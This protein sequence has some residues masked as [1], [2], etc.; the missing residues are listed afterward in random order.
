[1]ALRK[2]L[3][4]GILA[5]GLGLSGCRSA[6]PPRFRTWFEEPAPLVPQESSGNAFDGYVLAAMRASVDDA[7]G[8][9]RVNFPGPERTASL[10]RMRPALQIFSSAVRKPCDFEFRAMMPFKESPY[11]AGFR[12]IGRALVWQ[13]ED[14]IAANATGEIETRVAQ[15]AKFAM[16]LMRGGAPEA[17]LGFQILDDMRRALAPNLDQLSP[18]LLVSIADIFERA[19]LNT[20]W[21]EPAL[22]NERTTMLAGVQF[23]QDAYRSGDYTQLQ[24]Q[25]GGEVREAVE[26]FKQLRNR[27]AR[28]QEMYFEGFA[29]E[30]DRELNWVREQMA[31]PMRERTEIDFEGERR[32]WRRFS[33]HFF[34]NLRPLLDRQVRTEARTKLMILECR[35][36]AQIKS[37]GSAP[38]DLSAFPK[39]LISDPFTGRPFGYEADGPAF[40]L[41]SSGA[42]FVDNGGKT[43]DE[44]EAPDLTLEK[45]L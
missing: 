25:L 28:D 24:Q 30:I 10:Q 11:H 15:G 34:R 17:D 5:V 7:K 33:K 4:G 44:F 26:Y 43:N 1:M 39:P 21:F 32:P 41:Y 6:D 27:S 23:V 40:K 3:L 31:R 37:N 13:L 12:Q 14:A 42:D 35:I 16:D 9:E 18:S 38:T 19:T 36:V 2:V 8:I 45:G 29:A 20:E 22:E